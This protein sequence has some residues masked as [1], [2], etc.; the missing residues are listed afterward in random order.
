MPQFRVVNA[1]VRV[2]DAAV[3]V[4]RS[5]IYAVRNPDWKSGSVEVRVSAGRTKTRVMAATLMSTQ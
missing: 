1:A 5:D 4:N 2:V 3:H